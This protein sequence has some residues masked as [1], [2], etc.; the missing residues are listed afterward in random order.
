MAEGVAWAQSVICRHYKN[1][2]DGTGP[3]PESWHGGIAKCHF[4]N[5]NSAFFAR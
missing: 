1:Y 4:Q 3:N 2:R 5:T